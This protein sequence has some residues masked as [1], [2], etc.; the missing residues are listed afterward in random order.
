MVASLYEYFLSGRCDSLEGANGGYNLLEMEIRM[1]RIIVQLDKVIAKLGSI[2]ANQ[3]SLYAAIQ[4]GNRQIQTLTESVN[5]VAGNISALDSNIS[6]L[7]RSI[8]NGIDRQNSRLSAIQK[9][10]ELTA[11]YAE[12]NQKELEYMNR[13]DYLCGRNSDTFFNVPPS[14]SIYDI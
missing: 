3:W 12:R 1:D 4:D 10:S 14:S 7:G 2:Q 13:M 5:R 8:S 11:Y 9:S 6:N